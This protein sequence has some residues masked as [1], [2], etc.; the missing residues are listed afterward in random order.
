[1]TAD[2]QKTE[3]IVIRLVD[4]LFSQILTKAPP[5][6]I[7]ELW[8]EHVEIRRVLDSINEELSKLSDTNQKLK[9]G[10]RNADK[11]LEFLKWAD[12]IGIARNNVEVVD[13]FKTGLELKATGTI[14]KGHIIA[15][16]PRH[17]MI[18]LD[19]ARKSSILKKAFERDPIV[20]NMGNVGLALFVA[21]QWINQEKSKW[22]PYISVLPTHFTTPIFY[23]EQQLLNLKPSPIFEE[24]LLFYRTIARQFAYFFISITQ[25]RVYEH[26][27]K[28]AKKGDR[29]VEPP[30][31]Y[32]TPF[33]ITNFTPNLYM[34]SVGVVTT[35][36]NMVPSEIEQTRDGQVLMMPALIPVL[37]MA[38]HENVTDQDDENIE[39]LVCFSSEENVALITSH[40]ELHSGD[41]ATIFYGRRSGGEHL[42]HN[43]FVPTHENGF[44][45]F[46]LKIG[47]P[48]T[49]KDLEA[50]RKLVKQLI[51]EAYSPTNVF[52]FDLVNFPKQ[53]FAEELL[54]FSAIFVTSSPTKEN[55]ETP[56]SRQKAIEFLKNRIILLE[57]SYGKGI[58]RSLLSQ[59][60]ED[61][62]AARLKTA[63]IH[64]LQLARV[65]CEV[66][67]K[68]RLIA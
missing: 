54:I 36:V 39:D 27:Q 16:V 7:V 19:L 57:K 32:N 1:M 22:H 33:T 35:R 6:N 38:N 45:I 48:K 40:S 14:P 52:Q 55:V 37:D 68:S 46:K 4:G 31:L 66:L 56:E 41:S 28:N 59:I 44:D 3:E 47:I 17:A 21:A 8:K 62:D 53:P 50:K 61:G 20:G 58:D 30:V 34:W 18:S 13:S 29:P 25:N 12:Q 15:K 67:E 63:E 43:G 11:I 23:S 10:S 49:D 5:S 9:D 24:S 64:I 26:S 65:H 2:Q 51:P 42:L 60:G